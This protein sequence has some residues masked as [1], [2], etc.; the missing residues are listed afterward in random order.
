MSIGINSSNI[1]S[2]LAM[3]TEGMTSVADWSLDWDRDAITTVLLKGIG[4]SREG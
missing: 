4:G 1:G 2:G 3:Q